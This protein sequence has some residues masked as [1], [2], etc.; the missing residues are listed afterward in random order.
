MKWRKV[1]KRLKK[2]VIP[3]M[4]GMHVVSDGKDIMEIDEVKVRPAGGMG[5]EYKCIG[6]SLLFPQAQPY[7][8]EIENAIEEHISENGFELSFEIPKIDIKNLLIKD[9]WQ[10]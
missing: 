6:H 3:M 1:K 10:R 5:V 9:L 4:I 2:H 7:V 8:D